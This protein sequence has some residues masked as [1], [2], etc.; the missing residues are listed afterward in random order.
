MR[1][2]KRNLQGGDEMDGSEG[3]RAEEDGRSSRGQ[4]GKIGYQSVRKYGGK[5]EWGSGQG[6]RLKE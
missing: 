6:R 3:M 2:G 1:T 5:L 4:G